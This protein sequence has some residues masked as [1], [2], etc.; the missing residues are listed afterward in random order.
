MKLGG[1]VKFRGLEAPPPTNEESVPKTQKIVPCANQRGYT[2]VSPHQP[3][4]SFELQG[5]NPKKYQ[6]EVGTRGQLTRSQSPSRQQF[7]T[8]GTRYNLDCHSCMLVQMGEKVNQSRIFRHDSVSVSRRIMDYHAILV[9]TL[10]RKND[11][12]SWFLILSF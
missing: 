10:C 1:G 7:L 4:S 5:M 9:E 12:L 3:G 11:S 6:S 2:T 8:T